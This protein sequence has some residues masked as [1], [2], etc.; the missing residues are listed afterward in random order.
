MRII[1]GLLISVLFLNP[2]FGQKKGKKVLSD[3]DKGLEAFNNGIY[4]LADSFFTAS[5]N[6]EPSADAYFNRAICRFK[7]KDKNGYCE[8]M[9]RVSNMFDKEAGKLFNKNCVTEHVTY[10]DSMNQPASAIDYA[11]VATKK[12][13]NFKTYEAYSIANPIGTVTFSY[14]VENGDTIYS[15]NKDMSS[16]SFPGG[17]SAMSKYISANL[18]YPQIS[19]ENG[20]MGTVFIKFVVNKI[21]KIER[22]ENWGSVTDRFLVKEA[23][24]VVTGMPDW[25][26]ATYNGQPVLTQFLVPIRFLLN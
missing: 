16:A 17:E 5:V 21:G 13:Y 11:Y 25:Q 8:D 9:L 15:T 20:V 2:A 18:K 6:Y 26:P 10:L 24:R 19:K 14:Q 4:T 7:Q 3:Y 23:I 12:V 22:I 1:I